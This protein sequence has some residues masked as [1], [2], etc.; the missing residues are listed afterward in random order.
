MPPLRKSRLFESVDGKDENAGNQ[1]LSFPP[2]CFLP[3]EKYI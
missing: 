2:Q 3:Y 1:Y